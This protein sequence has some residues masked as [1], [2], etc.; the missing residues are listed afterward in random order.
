M[1]N[2]ILSIIFILIIGITF[3][4]QESYI[5]FSKLTRGVLDSQMVYFNGESNKLTTMNQKWD[6]VVSE[7][8]SVVLDT[9]PYKIPLIRLNGTFLRLLGTRNFYDNSKHVNIS[10]DGYVLGNEG[11]PITT[12]YEVEQMI[13]LKDFLDEKGINLLYVSQ[14]VKYLDDDY[15]K[16]QFGK[17][18]Y[19]NKNSDLFLSRIGDAGIDYLDL[20]NNIIEEDIDCKTLFYR[21]DHHWTVPAG[22]WAAEKIAEK[23]NDSCGYNIDLSLFNDENFQYTNYPN[24]WLGEQGRLVS[25]AYLPLDD[26]TLIEP[27]YDTDY[28]VINSNGETETTGDFGIFIDKNL[29]DS[30]EDIYSQ[31][32]LHYSYGRFDWNTV[33]NNN[34][35]YG[36]VLILTDSYGNTMAP[37]LSL[38]I[39]N[40]EV[41]EMRDTGESLRD[42]I[43]N[44]DYDTIIIA[45]ALFELG[46]HTSESNYNYRMFDF[47]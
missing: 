13:M 15:F 27:L 28:S 20:R 21:T 25:D 41:I 40:M 5:Q 6:P 43:N 34:I 22:K 16:Q 4:S 24:K 17:D 45:Y 7:T 9:L 31:L 1:R 2:K 44:G 26:F 39:E 12:D 10:T 36:N 47:E 46:C 3:I 11:S 32:S 8:S 37:F 35:D 29:I 23:L 33:H 19:V 42:I 38:G 18:S 14:P 30:E